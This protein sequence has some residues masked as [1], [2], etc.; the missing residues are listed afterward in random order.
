MEYEV[1]LTLEEAFHGA[2]RL[3]EI[4]GRRV[5]V[6]IPPWCYRDPGSPGRQGGTGVERWSGG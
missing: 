6:S 4:D 2:E 3:M 1:E 5:Q